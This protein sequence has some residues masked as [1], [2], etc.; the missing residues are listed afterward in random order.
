MKRTI[1]LTIALLVIPSFLIGYLGIWQW[2]ICRHYCE[3]GQSPRLTRKTGDVGPND[4][5]ATRG[6]KGVVEQMLGPG[7]H[8]YNPW[9]YDLIPVT[10][11]TIPP[12]KVGVVT[13]SLGKDL[14]PNRYLAGPG[15]K[16]VQR[17]VL[18]PGAWRVN[19]HGA[20]VDVVD[21][22]KVPAGYVGVQTL[23]AGANQGVL[24]SVL[25][26][27]TYYLN[28]KEI[29]VDIVEVGYRELSVKTQLDSKGLPIESSGVFFPT[30]DGFRMFM[31][32]TVIWGI[33]PEN[34][35]RIIREYG[36]VDEVEAKIIVP[37]LDSVCKLQGSR[38]AVRQFIVGQDRESFQKAL[39]DDLDRVAREKG[40]EIL[41]VLVR[42]IFPPKQVLEPIQ[43][44]RLAD[45]ERQT[46]VVKKDT[47]AESARLEEAKKKVE[48]TVRD[49]TAENS[50]LVE[51]ERAEG[52]KTAANTDADTERLV[53][54]IA[55]QTAAIE[56][57]RTRLLG[58]A[59]ADVVDAKRRADADRYQRFVKA[60]GDAQTY[61]L[62]KFAEGLPAN[63]DLEFRYTG[64]GTFWTD[65]G[66]GHKP[67][68]DDAATKL[69]LEFLQNRKNEA[70]AEK[71]P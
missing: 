1:L 3:V 34:A 67:V 50:K 46:L 65:A 70:A 13:T 60:Y 15:E 30:K 26:P 9:D 36:N 41:L 40:I 14:P 8:F 53:A 21:A 59:E 20:R 39:N 24:P 54:D 56:A 69:L 38:D 35:P 27:G 2:G 31:D 52:A 71:T 57:D 18:T 64:P 32:I 58:Q 37:Q 16:G 17:Q 19:S 11:V 45:E 28:P 62:A 33:K 7:R 4:A 23:L 55:A 12:G 22:V 49:Y 29:K 25:Q 61:N 48:I 68:L 42:G 43:Q 66:S 44:A 5:F 47:D 51:S 6:Q 10:D 63:L